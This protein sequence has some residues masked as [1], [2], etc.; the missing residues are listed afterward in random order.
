MQ[1]TLA[2]INEWLNDNINNFY[3]NQR[4][5]GAFL[6]KPKASSRNIRSLI[7]FHHNDEFR[8]QMLKDKMLT[9][10]EN[11]IIEHRNRIRARHISDLKENTKRTVAY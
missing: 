1:I 9:V 4:V 2:K 7:S 8:R 11:M 5:R 3:R 6:E 10:A